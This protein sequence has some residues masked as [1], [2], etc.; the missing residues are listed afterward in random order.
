MDKLIGKIGLNTVHVEKEPESEREKS[1]V[2]CPVITLLELQ[3]FR[4]VPSIVPVRPFVRRTDEKV[5]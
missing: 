1:A 3:K 4:Y 5:D 2:M